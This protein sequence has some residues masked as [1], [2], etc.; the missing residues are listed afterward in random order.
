MKLNQNT[1]RVVFWEFILICF[2][3]IKLQFKKWKL[4]LIYFIKYGLAKLLWCLTKR[5]LFSCVMT[6]MALVKILF[7]QVW[8]LRFLCKKIRLC[9]QKSFYNGYFFQNFINITFF[10]QISTEELWHKQMVL[11]SK[12]N[13]VIKL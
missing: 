6:K 1:F 7:C 8:I 3:F 10:C 11:E 2:N 5:W 12:Q 9:S 4:Y 13:I